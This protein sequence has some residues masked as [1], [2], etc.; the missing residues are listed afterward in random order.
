MLGSEFAEIAFAGRSNV[1]KSSLLN[2]LMGRRNL[3]RT[4]STPGCTRQVNVFDVTLHGGKQFRFA[5]LPGFG[6]ARRS[7]TEREHWG[8]LMDDY[9]RVR[10][11]LRL[12]VILVDIR[13]GPR[14]LEHDLVEFLCDVRSTP[15]PHLWVATKIDKL[16]RSASKLAVDQM[17]KQV[18]A[19]VIGFSAATGQGRQAL[20]RSILSTG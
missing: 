16:S 19:P 20:W 5:D 18:A 13:R 3:V 12:V 9:F 14:Q 15:I 11:G 8:R 17:A 10:D 4:S 1:G 7:K 6:Y 2:T